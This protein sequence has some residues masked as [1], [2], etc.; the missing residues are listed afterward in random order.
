M[1][2]PKGCFGLDEN[3]S[4]NEKDV[5]MMKEKQARVKNKL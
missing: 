3:E 5:K 1:K 4:E 2:S